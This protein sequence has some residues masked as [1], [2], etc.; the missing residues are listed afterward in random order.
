[1]FFN[2]F[3]P[4]NQRC[5]V[6]AICDSVHH[7]GGCR[8]GILGEFKS[9]QITRSNSQEDGNFDSILA[10]L[11]NLGKLNCVAVPVVGETGVASL[12]DSLA[13]QSLLTLFS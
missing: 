12:A 6:S 8:L 3:F 2:S 13:K 1:V 9:G 7:Q 11:C 10:E 4:L 5:F